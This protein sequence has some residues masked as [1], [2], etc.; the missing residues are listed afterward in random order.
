MGVG[1]IGMRRER[2]VVE[3]KVLPEFGVI[4]IW[5]RH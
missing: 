2:T 1:T 3:K 4:E 5:N